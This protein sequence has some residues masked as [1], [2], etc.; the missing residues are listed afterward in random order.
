MLRT[1]HITF[2]LPNAE[3][4]TQIKTGHI[5]YQEVAAEIEDLLVRVEAESAASSLPDEPD[6]EWIDDFVARI[7]RNEICR[8]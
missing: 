1:G 6:R 8:N 3:H 7:Y 4:V 5:A 2:P